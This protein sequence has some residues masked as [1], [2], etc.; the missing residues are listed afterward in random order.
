MKI[1]VPHT[2]GTSG[3]LEYTDDGGS[4][5]IFPNVNSGGTF[6]T[7]FEQSDQNLANMV[8]ATELLNEAKQKQVDLES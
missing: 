3:E 5:Y 2:S 1:G 6:R 8:K 7:S 4:D